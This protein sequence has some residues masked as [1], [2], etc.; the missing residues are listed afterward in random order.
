MPITL[1]LSAEE[2]RA[3]AARAARDGKPP[4]QWIL[5]M[6]RRELGDRVP[7]DEALAPFRR[8]VGDSGLSD[9]ELES[10]F[11]DVREEVWRGKHPR[12]DPA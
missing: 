1:N 11:E 6:L 7:A 2:E 3:L 5:D 9:E 10:F 12:P 4:H 8:Q